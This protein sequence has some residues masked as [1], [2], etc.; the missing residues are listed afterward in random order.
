MIGKFGKACAALTMAAGMLVA[1]PAVS[2]DYLQCAPFA[3]A[4]SGVQLF[5]N[6]KSWWG[7]A[8]GTYAR[9]N[10]PRQGAVLAFASTSSMPM[11]H[12]AVVRKVLNDRE[13]MIDHANWSPIGGRRGQVERNVRVKDVSSA[14]DWSVVRV[15][16]APIGDLGLRPNPVQGFIYP[17]G[18][19]AHG[20]QGSGRSPSWTQDG[21]K[22]GHGLDAVISS[23]R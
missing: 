3:R 7:Q 5:G 12:V 16:Y 1:T 8:A 19:A 22:P 21:W 4:E 2:S 6:A 23:L 20:L 10:E 15:W 18:N 11:G 17:E 13:I 14:N 9:G